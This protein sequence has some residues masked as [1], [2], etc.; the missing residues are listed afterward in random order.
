MGRSGIALRDLELDGVLAS[1][2]AAL[3]VLGA[4]C[5]PGKGQGGISAN[6][7]GTPTLTD[8]QKAWLAELELTGTV[9]IP[10][11]TNAFAD[12]P[13]AARF[14]QKLFFYA[15]FSGPLLDSDNDGGSQALGAK[16]ET[17][18][19]SCAGCHMPEAG[20]SD[21][22]SRGR[23][24]SLA[25]GWVL[26]RTPSLLDVGQ[27]KLLTWVAKSD[28]FLN[29]V[30]GPVESALEMNSSRLFVAQEVGRAFREDYESIFGELPP[31][32]DTARFPVLPP[33]RAGCNALPSPLVTPV[34][35]GRPGD[36]AEFDSMS[37]A[38]QD[39]VTRVVTNLG[40]AF[41]AYLRK[42]SC[43]P[44]RFDAWL[45]GQNEALSLEEQRGAGLFVGKAGC[46]ECHGGPHLSD[47]DFHNVGLEP[48]IVAVAFID[49][50]DPGASAGLAELLESPLNSKGPFSDGDDQRL[51]EA[52]EPRLLGAFAT[53]TLRCVASR[54]SFMHT[55]QFR[56]L[57]DVIAFFNAGGSMG[58]FP[59][60][61]ELSPLRLS[62]EER[63][64]LVAFLRALE[65][66][67]PAPHL[68]SPP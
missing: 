42:L 56:T 29:Q 26:R 66:P 49:R 37:P 21:A 68:L 17:G 1:A 2:C 25:S 58:G 4:A 31:F 28:S 64:D 40:K 27:R 38:D 3:V 22:R 36:G 65:G 59:G 14:G 6:G 45:R 48:G 60:T 57:E 12:D 18:R 54:P 9:P 43:G 47:F 67:G 41:G 19:V 44:G 15:G 30:F 53:P 32:E 33:E 55:G 34:C 52:V 39:A 63:S 23:Q 50:D 35:A 16:G 11:L 24:I 13:S 46:I 5:A 51:P 62:A 61:S 20:F 10:D 7:A 8:E